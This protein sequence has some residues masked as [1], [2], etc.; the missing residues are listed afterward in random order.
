MTKKI[1][2]ISK[3]TPDALQGALQFDMSRP[4]TGLSR[5]FAIEKRA[6]FILGT[7]LSILVFSYLYFVAVSIYSVIAKADA[8]RSMREV[9]SELAHLEGEYLQVSTALSAS[10]ATDMGYT[11]VSSV[12]YVYRPHTTALAQI[13]NMSL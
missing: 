5:E 11:K 8:E 6:I 4:R 2:R 3:Y 10:N 9:H 13:N 7:I 1:L 12:Q